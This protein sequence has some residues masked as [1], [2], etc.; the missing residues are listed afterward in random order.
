MFQPQVPV[1]DGHVSLGRRHNQRVSVADREAVWAALAA[2]GTT[3]ALVYHPHGITFE[4][5]DGNRR[6][7]EVIAG[8]P[9]LAP[10]FVVNLAVDDPAAMA[11][12]VQAAGVRS[13]RI[14]PKPTCIP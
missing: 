12:Q 1:F 9:R 8:N 3:R 14:C 10:Q 11:A 5:S 6:L 4:S 2:A 7:M 13:L